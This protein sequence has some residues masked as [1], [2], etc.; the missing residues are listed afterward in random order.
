MTVFQDKT[1]PIGHTSGNT[2]L[3]C[4][5]YLFMSIT[6][7]TSQLL[8][9]KRPNDATLAQKLARIVDGNVLIAFSNISEVVTFSN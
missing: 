7:A 5:R 9:S 1:T 4:S 2:A 3:A 6:V 8:T